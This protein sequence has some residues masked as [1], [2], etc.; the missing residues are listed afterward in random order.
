MR[1]KYFFF[2]LIALVALGEALQIL[3]IWLFWGALLS[4]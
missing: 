4:R 1:L 3:A 2:I